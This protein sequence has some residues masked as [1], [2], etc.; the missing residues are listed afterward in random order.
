MFTP[1]LVESGFLGDCGF[2][3]EVSFQGNLII[4]QKSLSEVLLCKMDLCLRF[5]KL[6]KLNNTK[7]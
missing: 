1:S 3:F 6:S 4:S 7:E 5:V 2:H